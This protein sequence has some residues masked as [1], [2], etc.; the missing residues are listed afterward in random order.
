[1]DRD[2]L[3]C[4][5]STPTC[6]HGCPNIQAT[7]VF[8]GFLPHLAVCSRHVVWLLLGN[9]FHEILSRNQGAARFT[10]VGSGQITAEASTYFVKNKRVAKEGLSE[11]FTRPLNCIKFFIGRDPVHTIS[12]VTQCYDRLALYIW[13]WPLAGV[14]CNRRVVKQKYY[15][16]GPSAGTTNVTS[17]VGMCHFPHSAWQQTGKCP[18][19]R[20]LALWAL[21]VY[22][23]SL[24][25]SISFFVSTLILLVV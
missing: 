19:D 5:E 23:T 13:R 25:V 6:Q 24:E 3:L 11:T 21:S 18:Q 4:S 20:F 22:A 12:A 2:I 1:M 8:A 9:E 14:F 10:G 16:K 7:Q 17:P 15:S